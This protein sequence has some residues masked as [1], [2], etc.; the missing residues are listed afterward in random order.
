MIFD[1]R[2]GHRLVDLVNELELRLTGSAPGPG[3]DP[4]LA[5]AVPDAETYVLVLF[6]GLGYHQ[7]DHPAA[8]SLRRSTQGRLAAPFPSTTTVSLTTVASG[9]SPGTH[10]VIGHLMWLPDIERVANTLKWISPW[11]E[12]ITYPTETLVPVPNLWERLSAAGVEPIT[13]Q[14]AA[15]AMSPLTAALYRGCR[16]EG[17]AGPDDLVEATVTLARRPGR[18]IFTYLQQVDFC[19]H[20]FGQASG[21]YGSAISTVD[22][23]WAQITA[24][25]SPAAVAVG[26]ADHGHIDYA[27]DAKI[28]VRGPAADALTFFG[29][30]RSLYVNGD[31]DTILRVAADNGAEVSWS[32]DVRRALPGDPHPEL[33]GRLPTAL[34]AAPPGRVL[35][36]RGFDRR[37]IGYHGGTAREEIEI[38]MLVAGP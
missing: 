31:H 5:A 11:G 22:T 10:G 15:F 7:L 24:R 30:P 20:L 4:D 25:L 23:A 13:V 1:Q 32:A 35:L 16:F 21:E 34:L 12:P 9:T 36:P 19:A 18:L 17:I 3:L 29:D 2:T 26:T 8:G 27:D 38:P 37:L 28:L 14:P 6:D 33:E